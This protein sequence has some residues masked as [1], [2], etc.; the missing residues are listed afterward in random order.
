MIGRGVSYGALSVINAIAMGKGAGFGIDLK[1]EATVRLTAEPGI[2]VEIDGHPSEDT[3]LARFSVDE[4]LRRYPE[5]GMH[6]AV[7]STTSNIPISQGLISSSA[8]TNAIL[9]ALADALAVPLH[10]LAL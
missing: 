10:P 8:A 7:I 3:R 5:S 2:V 4:L 6:G 9:A 1:T